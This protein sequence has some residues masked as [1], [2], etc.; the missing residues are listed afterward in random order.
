MKSPRK[1]EIK[2]NRS[3]SSQKRKKTE[4]ERIQ[5]LIQRNPGL[6]VL[7]ARNYVN[8]FKPSNVDQFKPTQ[9]VVPLSPLPPPR[10]TLTWAARAKIAQ[11]PYA[12]SSIKG[13]QSHTKKRTNFLNGL[14]IFYSTQIFL[15]ATVRTNQ[16]HTSHH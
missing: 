15:K 11:R 16:T 9:T 3:Q 10:P 8:Q 14:I 2:L 13:F 6:S 7:S 5:F 4:E 12:L 1:H